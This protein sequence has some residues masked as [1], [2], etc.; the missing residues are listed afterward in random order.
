MEEDQKNNAVPPAEEKEGDELAEESPPPEEPEL[1]V[2]DVLPDITLK[3]EKGDDVRVKDL[4]TPEQGVVFFLVPKAD[5][6]GC[7]TQACAFRDSY[8]EFTEVKYA[9]YCVSADTS[10]AQ[11]R[12]QLKKELPF[13]L[14]SDPQRVFIKAL[15]AFKPPKSTSRSHFVFE[16]GTGKLVEKKSSV[17]PAES[18]KLA[19]EFI[20]RHHAEPAKVAPAETEEVAA[21]PGAGTV[22]TAA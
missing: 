19:L 12:W 11:A 10:T 7:T 14:L 20:K 21:L 1:Q 4:A 3:N 9:V 13:P 15:G 22:E 16:K 6:P 17:K 8:S 2:G 5:T 18:S